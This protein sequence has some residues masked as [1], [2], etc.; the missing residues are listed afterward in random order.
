[1]NQFYRELLDKIKNSDDIVGKEYRKTKERITHYLEGKKTIDYSGHT[2]LWDSQQV[3]HKNRNE[4]FAF[5]KNLFNK[6]DDNKDVIMA[7]EHF[8]TEYGVKEL[9]VTLRFKCI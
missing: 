6:F 9:K 8:V 3:F 7:Q 1:M 5:T 2:L 4:V